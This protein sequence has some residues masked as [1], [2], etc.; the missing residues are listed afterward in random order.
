MALTRL[1]LGLTPSQLRRLDKIARKLD[2]DRTN[3]LRYCIAK[4]AEVE[5][6]K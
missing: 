4:T 3:A 1:N 5:N 2:M 6:V